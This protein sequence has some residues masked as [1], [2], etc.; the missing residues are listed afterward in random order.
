MEFLE[1]AGRSAI[2]SPV[3]RA[4]TEGAPC[5]L[6]LAGHTLVRVHGGGP[7]FAVAGTATPS[8]TRRG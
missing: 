1:E 7:E 4:L 6:P 8:A 2:R 3:I 5:P